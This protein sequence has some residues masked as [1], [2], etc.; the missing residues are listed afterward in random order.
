MR[1]SKQDMGAF[2]TAAWISYDSGCPGTGQ[3]TPVMSVGGNLAPGEKT[4]LDCSNARASASAALTIGLK[5]ATLNLGGGCVLLNQPLLLLFLT[6]NGGGSVSVPATIPAS[7]V[8]TGVEIYVQYGIADSAAA[9]G[10]ATSQ[11]VAV[12][13]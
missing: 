1:G 4:S 3:K 8:L 9:A 12:R 11:G 6:T 2:E 10:I 5:K 13:L 7:V